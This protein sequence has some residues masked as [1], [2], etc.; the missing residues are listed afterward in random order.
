VR[1]VTGATIPVVP[2]PR[3]PGDPAALVASSARARDELD[4]LPNKPDL[5]SI[6][7]DA[8]NFYRTAT[9]SR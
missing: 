9:P 4:W 5:R 7:R 8:W 3:R 6:V 1:A 2:A